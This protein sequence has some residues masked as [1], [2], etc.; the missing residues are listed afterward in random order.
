MSSFLPSNATVSGSSSLA[1][2]R[3]LDPMTFTSRYTVTK[4]SWRGK[5]T[6]I[7]CIGPSGLATCD[8]RSLSKVTNYW[9]YGTVVQG[10]VADV[11]A[12]G[13]FLLQLLVSG[14]AEELRFSCRSNGERALLLTDVNR[15][16]EKFDY[17]YRSHKDACVYPA[18]KY[19]AQNTLRPCSLRITAVG[20]E[21][22]QQS[23]PA[24]TN[25]GTGGPSSASIAEETKGYEKIGEYAFAYIR[26]ITTIA[27]KE[28]SVVIAYGGEMKLHL[29]TAAKSAEL[30]KMATEFAQRYT[31]MPPYRQMLVLLQSQ[32]DSDRL[33]FRRDALEIIAEFPVT[34]ETWKHRATPVRRLLSTA[35]LA[36]VERDPVTYGVISAHL[37]ASISYLVRC[38]EDDQRFVV[39]YSDAEMKK[40]YS[41]PLRDSILAHLLTACHNCGNTAVC[42]HSQQPRR[43]DRLCSF[44]SRVSEEVESLLLNQLVDIGSPAD[45]DRGLLL[46]RLTT[47]RE[48]FNANIPYTGLVGCENKEG[49]FAENREKLIFTALEAVLISFRMI[50]SKSESK[51]NHFLLE[52]F[53]ALRR[54]AVSRVGYSSIAL[55]PTL[56]TAVGIYS[57]L[58]L[59]RN[60]LAIS[61]AVVDFLNALMTPFHDHYELEHESINKNR[62]LSADGF[63]RSLL[64]VLRSHIPIGSASLVV[65]SLLLFFV[66]ALCPPYSETT[67]AAIFST[68]L[69]D[70]VE[71][72]GPHLF[73]LQGHPCDSI[74]LT[75]GQLVRV[76]MEEGTTDQFLRMQHWALSEA[77]VLCQLN[78]AIFGTH[79][80]LRDLAR[81]LISHCAFQNVE[82]QDLL[83]RIVPLT[84]LNFL[85]YSDNAPEEEEEAV[86]TKSVTQM[87][88]LY[89]EAKNGWLKK[90]F[91]PRDMVP[92]G[93]ATGGTAGD[94]GRVRYR[95]R[96][97]RQASKLN[98]NLFFAKIKEDHRRPDLIWN[99]TTRNELRSA[100]DAEWDVFRQCTETRDEQSQI[101]WNYPEFEVVYHSLDN[102]L[103]IGQHYPRLLFEDPN[104]IIAKP[105]DFFNDLYHRFLLV[106]DVASK[107]E[108]LH[109]LAL[110]CK[111]YPE[112]IG[113]FNDVPFLLQMLRDA[114]DPCMRDRILLLILQLLKARHNIKLFL[115]HDGIEPLISLI[116]L[117]HLHIDR[118]QIR[119]TTNAIEYAG[120]LEELQGR[121]K[122]WH[123][124]KGGSKAAPVSFTELKKLYKTGEITS[125]TKVWAQGMVGWREFRSVSQLRWGVMAADQPSVLTLTEV[126]CVVLDILNLLCDHFPSINIDGAVV[127]PLPKVKRLL[128][129]PLILPSLVQLLLTF[130]SGICTRVHKLLL[131]LMEENPVVGRFFLTGVFF[132]SMMYTASDVVP[133]CR[134]LALT[135]RRQAFQ[136]TSASSDMVRDSILSPLLPPAMVCFLTHHGPERFA[137]VLLGEYD[138]PEAIWSPSMRQFLASKIAA[139]VGDF[140]SRLLANNNVVYQYCPIVGLTYEGLEKELFC[141]QYYLRHLCDELRFPAWPLQQPVRFL[142]EVLKAWKAELNKKPAL[143]S[144][145]ECLEV[146]E[147]TRGAAEEEE[148][149]PL[150]KHTDIRRAYYQLAAR[151]HPDKNPSG[152]DM[153]D[154]I[155]LAY[156]VLMTDAAPSTLPNPHHIALLLKAQSIL[157]K[158]CGD[159]L[160]E[161]K[162]AG[163]ELLL[164]LLRS[165]F[166]LPDALNKEIVLLDPGTELCYFTILN[167][168]LNADELQEEHGIALLSAIAQSCFDR[169]TP[170]SKDHEAQVRV[171]KHC[172]L[173]FSISAQ[174]V[175]C[176]LKMLQEPQITYMSARG[177]AYFDAPE[178]SRACIEAC[179]AEARSERMQVELIQYGA[180]WHLLRPLF[181]YDPSLCSAGVELTEE[182]HRQ[183]FH[184][185][186]A[187]FALRALDA[188]AGISTGNQNAKGGGQTTRH[189]GAYSLLNQLLTR[190]V[191]RKLETREDTD[192]EILAMLNGN[193]DTPYFLWNNTCRSEL[194]ELV[195]DNSN[196]CREAA[197]G[198]KDLPPPE[199]AAHFVYSLHQ[200]EVVVGGVFLRLFISQSNFP[201]RDPVGLFAALLDRL[202]TDLFPVSKD[203]AASPEAVQC[204]AQS[205]NLVVQSCSDQLSETAARAMPQLFSCLGCPNLEPGPLQ[206]LLSALEKL[207]SFAAC[208][209]ACAEVETAATHL[210][211]LLSRPALPE[212]CII[213]LLSLLRLTFSHR[214]LIEQSLDRGL[215][216]PLL[217]LYATTPIE[218][219]REG[220]CHCLAKGFA[221]RLVGPQLLLR[222]GKYLPSAFLEMMRENV[223]QACRM[224]DAQY[225]NPELLWTPEQKRRLISRL[226]VA[227]DAIAAAL[228]ANPIACWKPSEDVDWAPAV[229][230]AAG[231]ETLQIAGVYV[232]LYVEQP[233]WAVRKPR[234]FVMGLLDRFAAE[235]A[236]TAPAETLLELLTTAGV[237]LLDTS[238]GLRDSV[239]SLG[240]GSKLVRLLFAPSPAVYTQSLRWLRD[241]GRSSP[242]VEAVMASTDIFPPLLS[243]LTAAPAMAMVV[244]ETMEG[245]IRNGARRSRVV[246]TAFQDEV[247]QTLLRCLEDR[248]AD[249]LSAA[250][251]V[252]AATVR[253]AL[254]KV[255]KAMVT[256]PDEACVS[257][258]E[259]LLSKSAVWAKYKSQSHDLFLT[260][261]QLGGYLM[262]ASRAAVAPAVTLSL[263]VGADGGPSLQSEPPPLDGCGDASSP[264]ASPPS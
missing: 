190:E 233:G 136:N 161:Y 227:S 83:R 155:Q 27:E 168:P 101:A 208:L 42:V 231:L 87:T 173:T 145:A 30:I 228:T 135:H 63:I 107:L 187:V 34:K 117:A 4:H 225:M 242:C 59:R 70:M 35:P 69:T 123:Y 235:A 20:I 5:Y 196:Q 165:E 142:A 256:K 244:L 9:D 253:A 234:D 195:A 159:A 127:Q 24:A 96:Q 243:L 158:R 218:E 85:Q 175:D 75:A 185:R 248:V 48:V 162:Y 129:G 151:Y 80:A 68:V 120:S 62:L 108:C 56:F 133:M 251:G 192:E 189:K 93:V 55:V 16:R 110:L 115:D 1:S 213:A 84:L 28:D 60:N 13:C 232:R 51:D 238:T 224:L 41:S 143:L 94:S 137:D 125:T 90:S 217:L 215:Y 257:R 179:A 74:R 58:A 139:H 241:F 229:D 167:A 148:T 236:T 223:T 134:L 204:V 191:M 206:Q 46:D 163:Y 178:L 169:I 172:M 45:E 86:A 22:L 11:E 249:E 239:A 149:A 250:A 176:R 66:Y 77:S 65:Q 147:L 154:K 97:L 37:L 171:A 150:P 258:I 109:G 220:C 194:L 160:K 119:A 100:L 197:I 18:M 131:S 10:I 254:V 186:A 264:S 91:N 78:T 126:A 138:T 183:V 180:V 71:I 33:G 219:I 181:F 146:L 230:G 211:F 105:L 116:T 53:L 212:P 50:E 252:S 245:F 202:G 89:R 12:A 113:Q 3:P 64:E 98:W 156:E 263:T 170:L 17:A 112:E 118:P 182:H 73:Y 226:Q 25:G 140:A 124:T 157:F 2:L 201:I 199:S 36:L 246:E 207:L 81:R 67:D 23:S 221:D 222:C 114:T 6:R 47:S 141:G 76:V 61:H 40:V 247:P 95:T 164:Q 103:K 38:A 54:L 261:T 7:F 102:E 153:F 72:V 122:E 205:L 57:V 193:S 262:P 99:D 31:G 255:I 198:A 174:F 79:R 52:Q 128:S 200:K 209:Q 210:F 49:L 44:R 106:P 132:F 237:T 184:N 111:F 260:Q 92:D 88:A 15:F 177:I 19:T 240:Y 8:V 152:R 82:M 259:Q 21:Q 214:R 26:G 216:I 188:L 166:A 203:V 32:F 104:P 29:F 39:A 144:R 121:D 130:D 14:K 43:A